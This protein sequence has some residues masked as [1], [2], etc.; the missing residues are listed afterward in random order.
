MGQPACSK[1]VQTDNR[2]CSSLSAPCFLRQAVSQGQEKQGLHI[3]LL[4]IPSCHSRKS[5]LLFCALFPNPG[6]SEVGT[7]HTKCGAKCRLSRLNNFQTSV[8]SQNT[9]VVLLHQPS[10]S[11]FEFPRAHLHVVGMLRFMF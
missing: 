5:L 6:S 4:A 9:D 3:C 7:L 8:S 1:L 11:L 2:G 10:S